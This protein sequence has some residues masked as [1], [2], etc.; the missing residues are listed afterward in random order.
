MALS[1]M[2][3][4]SIEKLEWVSWMDLLNSDKDL[5]ISNPGKSDTIIQ[6]VDTVRNS[7]LI[8]ILLKNGYH[9]LCTGPTGTGKSVTIQ[10][11]LMHGLETHWT[12]IIINF[13]SRTSANQIQDLIDSKLEK[14]RKGVFGPPVGKKFILFIDDLNMPQLDICNAQPPIELLR[15]WM[16]CRGWFDRKNIGKFMEVVDISFIC[17]MGPPGGGRNPVTSRFLRHF[18]LIS[19]VEME[20][21]SLKRI[22]SIILGGFLSKFPPEISKST[23]SIVD[24]SIMIYNTIRAELL[25]TPA[26]SHYT[27]NLRDLAKVIQGVLSADIKTVNVETDIV[28]LWIHECQRVFQ[29]RLVDNIDK[30]WFKDLMVITMNNKLD[31]SWD[32][33]VICEPLLYGDYMTP[34]ADPK[35]YTEVKDLRRLVKLTEE[36]LD[37]YNSSSTSPMKL[38]MFLD[39]IEHVSRICRI[40]RQPGGH[41]L[42]LGVGGSGRQSLSR[43]AA[44]MEEF[45][46]FQVEISK[47]YGQ[48]EW[49]DDL[50]KVLFAAGLDGKPTV[51]LYTDTQIIS[52]SN[53]EDINSILNGGDVPNIYTGEEM[54]RILN[55]IRPIAAEQSIS[56][57]RENLFAL[58]IQRIRSN[59][60][61]IICMSPIGDSFRNRLRMFPSLVNCCTI[62]WFSTWPEDALRSVAANSISEISDLGSELVID[63]IV[64]L[65]VFMHE[66]VRERCL[67]YRSELS[68]NNYVTPK[69][70]LELLGI[71]KR[72]LEKKR[73]ELIALRKR[74]ATGLEKLLN[75]TKEVEILQE[76]L[77]AMQPMLM[78]TS[79]ETEYAMK[80][81]AIDKIKGEEIKENVIKEELASSKKA[82]E[83]KAIA[84]D[85]KRDLDEALPA[86]DAA[87]ESLNSLSK[88]DIIEVRSMQRP[89]E[90]VKLVIEAICI[91]KGIKPKKIDGDKPGKKIDD[92]WEPG[93]ALLADPQRF[94]DSLMN[95]DKDNI[96]E[97]TIQKIKPYIDSP[98]FQ[99]SVISRVSRAATSMCQWVRAM[100]KYYLVSRSVAPKRERLKEAQESLDITLKI[101]SELKKKMREAEVNIKEMEK[102]YAESV[103][104]KEEL[105]RKVEECNI[106]LSRAGK[107]ISGLSG[108]RQRWALAVDQ[109]DMR[110]GNIIGDILLSSGAIAYIGPFTA[111]YRNLLMQEWI[112]SVLQLKIPHSENTSLWEALGD[113]VK[114]REWEIFGL[115]KDSLSRDNAIVVQNSR[116]W[117]LLIDPQGQ[118]NK[119]IRNMEKDHS[120]DIIKLTDRDFLRTLENAI[121]FGRSVLLENV[122]EKL[123]PALE[124]ILLRQTFKQG[125]STVIKVGDNILPY[126][127]DFKFY[128]TTKLPNPHYSPETSAT[129]TLVNFTLAPSGLEDQ[130]LAIVVA[131]ERP[132]LEEAKSQL[133]INNSQMK[134]ELKEIEDKILYLLSSVQ[135]SP[136]D[137]ERLIETLGASK[138]TSEEIQQKVSAAE[139]TEQEID[140]TR[141]KYAPVAVRTR[142]MFF[143]I[144][145]L[146]NIDPMYQYSLSWFMNLFTS[147]I[148]HSEKS[149]NIE[150]RV[151]NINDYFTFSLF[152]NVCRSLFE[153]HKLLFSFLLTI[154]ILMN[155]NTIDMDEWRFLLTGGSTSD[156]QLQNP[157]SDWLSAQSWG[158]ILSLSTLKNFVGFENDFADF[159]EE[160]MAMFDSA[161]PHR[162]PLP[163][164]WQNAL[165]GFQKLLVLR[166]LRADRITSGIQDFVAIQLGDRFIE[167]QTSDLSA[168]FKESN[169]TTPLI[170]V[171]SSGADP[172][173]SLYKFAED[174][175]MSKKLTSVSLGQGQGPRAEALIKEG[176]ER[177]LW[178]L[179]QNCHLSPSWM[180]SLDR[181]IDSITMDKVH[182]DF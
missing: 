99:V 96:A 169:P 60:H 71:Y 37:D 7:F 137:D 98:E 15:Q 100:E 84:E 13:S 59:L 68:R 35:I 41:A 105:S 127:D 22:F 53:L 140:T 46:Q 103:A 160:Y 79:Q 181:V 74:T 81:I 63:G 77:E 145:E 148:N 18:N 42:L 90:G 82:E 147:A 119:W 89:P 133:T 120:L 57:T 153:K 14:R 66:S 36:Y 11:K 134:R 175:R 44:F 23:D 30:T 112:G 182:R 115:P 31:V 157:A 179:L 111:E 139:K 158:E 45:E 156:K 161:L 132:D 177:G 70:Y 121:R 155:D 164:K 171:L 83:T 12:P 65:C 110:I 97:I 104:K 125:G 58:Y 2:S 138:E 4:F 170:F 62:D 3:L 141:N 174:M 86:L 117:P 39:A 72:L 19:F 87:V 61:L 101:L 162:E 172:A 142:I 95:F 20:N 166:C 167:P 54:D 24:A 168:L 64:N 28:R 180:P 40:I 129:V 69:S 131:N 27:F 91:M 75:A 150:Q 109:F 50:K 92:Y 25:P 128:I 73:N 102:R 159:A 6:T 1:T 123:D 116:R 76:E 29:D 118:A 43:L 122:G 78:Q 88:N 152:T 52:E 34:G 49:R 51:F 17:A 113:N 93:R 151:L 114:L 165:D 154:R 130:L 26:K 146:A 21:I 85:A 33:V 80:K 173:N 8:D 126:H 176:M 56:G 38:V 135:G 47:N 55:S 143:C 5:Q 106:K 107:L 10:E 48:T 9:V 163:G 108:E 144:T 94:L 136:V 178:I 149:E 124:P 16:D 32:E 67:T